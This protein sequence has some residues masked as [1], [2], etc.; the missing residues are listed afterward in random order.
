MYILHPL[1]GASESLAEEAA[2]REEVI[3]HHAHHGT[4]RHRAHVY[5]PLWDE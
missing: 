1:Q 5:I 2:E 4:K 3:G